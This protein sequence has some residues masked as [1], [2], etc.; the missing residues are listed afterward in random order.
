M[1]KPP[2]SDFTGKLDRAAVFLSG[3]C[4]LHC[5]ALPVL[6]AVFPLLGSFFIPHETFH[7]LILVIVVPTTALA[8]GSG[9]RCHHRLGV[10]ALGALGV[11]GLVAAAFTVHRL[12]AEQL[13]RAMTIAGG[14]ILACAH[15]WNFQL[16]RARRA[17]HT[18]PCGQQKMVETRHDGR[19]ARQ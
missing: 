3:L 16:T 10:L 13:E 6:L 1:R 12:E 5:L 15:G 11:A 19:I 2:S 8:L 9:Y 18:A 4:L 7:Q 17:H 14:L